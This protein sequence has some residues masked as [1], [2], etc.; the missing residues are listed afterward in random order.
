MKEDTVRFEDII[1]EHQS[2]IHKICNIYA[3]SDF[4]KEELFQEITIQLWRSYPSFR[5]ESKLSTW[6]YRVA[7]NTALNRKKKHQKELRTVSLST[8]PA[9][10]FMNDSQKNDY[11]TLYRAI[12]KLKPVERAV[13]LLYL[14]ENS[15]KEIA[16]IIGIT[17]KNVSVKIVRIKAKLLTLIKEAHG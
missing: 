10:E 8:M 17:V 2:I 14:D 6:L 3:Q 16:E 12:S 5:G 9:K 4:D 1:F 7:L 15:H 13:I 11:T